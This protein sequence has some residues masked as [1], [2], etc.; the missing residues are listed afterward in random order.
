MQLVNPLAGV[1]TSG[2]DLN[3]MHPTLHRIVPHYGTDLAGRPR[4]G[5]HPV[6]A[7]ADGTVHA[8]RGNWPSGKAYLARLTGNY[9]VLEHAKIGGKTFRTYYGH[10][11]RVDVKPGQRVKAGDVIGTQGATGDVDGAHLHL[12]VWLG[13]YTTD[14][15]PFFAGYGVLLGSGPTTLPESGTAGLTI[16]T[17]GKGITMMRRSTLN[18]DLSRHAENVHKALQKDM[19]EMLASLEHRLNQHMSRHAENVHRAVQKDMRETLGGDDQ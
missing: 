13:G 4:G 9:V 11:D 10:L 12:E 18:K 7:A 2:Y 15:E 14:P 1:I 5:T 16:P 6:H 19:R 17:S 3:R 8:V